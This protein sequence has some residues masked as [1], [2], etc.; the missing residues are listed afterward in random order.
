LSNILGRVSALPVAAK[1][2]LAVAALIA[3]GLSVLLSPLV[4]VLAVLIL[5]VAVLAVFIQLLPLGTLGL[6]LVEPDPLP[7]TAAL[8]FGLLT[9]DALLPELPLTA[10]PLRLA[11]RWVSRRRIIASSSC[12]TAS[13]FAMSTPSRPLSL[14]D[15]I[16]LLS[17]TRN[18][19]LRLWPKKRGQPR[20]KRAVGMRTCPR[21]W[22]HDAPP[23]SVRLTTSIAASCV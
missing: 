21:V 2:F 10:L 22:T 23:S 7:R 3:L 12:S 19:C 15:S 9:L 14:P 1:V 16:V 5:I 18:K 11:A 13:P 8:V 6:V 20:P 4:V 17:L